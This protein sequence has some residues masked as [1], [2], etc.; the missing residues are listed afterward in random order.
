[1]EAKKS[2]IIVK[3]TEKIKPDYLM[4]PTY[5]V[6]ITLILSLIL[7]KKFIY[8]IDSKRDDL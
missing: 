2:S 5:V 6:V 4:A 3:S 7:L 8:I 1:M